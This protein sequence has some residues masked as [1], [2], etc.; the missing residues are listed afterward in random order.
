[1]FVCNVKMREKKKNQTNWRRIVFICCVSIILNTKISVEQTDFL[2]LVVAVM[3]IE[4]ICKSNKKIS[5][6]IYAWKLCSTH[7]KYFILLQFQFFCGFKNKYTKREITK[8]NKSK[9]TTT[10]KTWRT[11]KK[12]KKKKLENLKINS[13]Q[14]RTKD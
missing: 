7:I 3:K 1:M 5:I 9:K 14:R 8:K 11:L 6:L 12:Q 4:I 2:L 13:K 10:K